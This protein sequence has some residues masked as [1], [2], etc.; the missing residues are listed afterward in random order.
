MTTADVLLTA[1]ALSGVS[2][3]VCLALA[4]YLSR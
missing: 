3:F 2:A 1:A 4:Y